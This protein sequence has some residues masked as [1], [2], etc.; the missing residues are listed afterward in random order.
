[1]K[2]SEND[3]THLTFNTLTYNKDTYIIFYRVFVISDYFTTLN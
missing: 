1:M 3:L 2:I